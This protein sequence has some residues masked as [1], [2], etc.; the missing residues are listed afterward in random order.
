LASLSLLVRFGVSSIVLL[1]W[2]RRSL[3]GITRLEIKQGLGL[4][5]A[6]GVGLLFQ[7]DAVSHTSASTA[8][9]LTQCYC[10]LIPVFVA[11]HKR[12]WPKGSLLLSCGM[13]IA[14][15]AILSDFNWQEMQLGRGEAEAIIASIFFT[16]QILWLE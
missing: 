9:F 6:G 8:A 5:L 4:G 10:L 7:M 15:V 3:G 11:C 16:A 14:G 1:A 12:I 13:V 2:S